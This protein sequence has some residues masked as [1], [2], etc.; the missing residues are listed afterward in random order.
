MW[1]SFSSGMALPTNV[2]NPCS[3]PVSAYM[4]LVSIFWRKLRH[5]KWL[6]SCPKLPRTTWFQCACK[7]VL[8]FTARRIN[9]FYVFKQKNKACSYRV[10][11]LLFIAR[12][13]CSPGNLAS[14]LGPQL[15]P[16]PSVHLPVTTHQD[17]HL[18]EISFLL[19]YMV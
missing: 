7:P 13:S 14:G 12:G 19:Y 17:A 3:R 18:L 10:E 5:R 8:V 6:G 16:R 2:F 9:G 15:W 11:V 1:M 4:P